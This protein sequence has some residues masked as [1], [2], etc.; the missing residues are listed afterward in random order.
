M[1]TVEAAQEQ[2]LIGGRWT[3][4]GSDATFDVKSP[5]TGEV[6]G[7]AAAAGVAD[8]NAAVDAADA[9]FRGWATT[10]PARRRELLNA[11]ADLMLERRDA[12]AQTMT[13]ETGATFGWGAF[14]TQLAAGM[15]R[16]AAAQAYAGVGE[17]IPSDVPGKLAMAVRAPVGVV[18]GIAPWNGPII[19]G[20]RAVATPLAFGNTVV[21][22]GSELCP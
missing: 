5:Y 13:E 8:A 19:L 3:P 15:L 16:E 22:K 14:N 17:V 2:L 18:V 7:S 21:L 9:A 11:A 12:I 20:T 6:V 1:S 4:A 10:P